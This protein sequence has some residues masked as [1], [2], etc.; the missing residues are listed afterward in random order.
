M[1]AVLLLGLLATASA[2]HLDFSSGTLDGWTH[3]D[4][5]K[6]EGKFVVATPEG[7]DAVTAL[8]VPEKAKHYGISKLLPAAV[9]PAS[10]L[11]LQFDLK[12]TN[13]LSCGGAYIKFVT[14]E[15]SF[16]PSGLKD[17]TPYTVM[18]GPD[19][20]GDTNKVHLILRHKSPKTGKIE[21]KHLQSP[22]FVE[23][24][25]KTHV[26]TAILRASNNSYAVLVDGEEK[27]SGSLFDDFEPPINP[28]E[29]I[30]DP[31]DKK[32]S[33][34]VD[35]ARI[36]DPDAKKPEDW[37]EDAPREIPDEDAKKPEGWLDEEPDEVD[38]AEAKKPEDW[39]DE[40]DGD[41][42]P[43]KVPNPKCKDAPG[44]GEWKRPS[45][46]N[47]AYKGK[48]SAPM[49]D[50]PAY[51]GVWKPREIPNPEH[52]KDPAPLTNIGK[53]GAAAIEI[54]TMDDGYFFDNVVVSNSEA[55]AA[56]VREKSWAPKKVIEDAK[57]AEEKAKAEEAAKKAEAEAAP[58]AAD[59][60]GDD[61]DDKETEE[62]NKAEL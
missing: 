34:W 2:V 46:P 1:R 11:V 28:P 21:E 54:W 10:D 30:P 40:E 36:A 59:D 5:G 22:P 58:D 29:T 62:E 19:K 20:C 8:K 57:E 42:E 14:D 48:W 15:A 26:Y 3:S 51:K 12:L 23:T 35:E 61:E 44:C 25:S 52:N 43:P 18:F 50:N 13:G 16:T 4:D 9:D 55:E 31:E 17:D 33:D 45:K 24:D 49:I 6:Y 53:V 39:D 27:K 60:D 38:D 32:P 41:W 7:L 56:E 47:P 37:D